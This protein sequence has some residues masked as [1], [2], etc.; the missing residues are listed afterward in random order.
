MWLGLCDTCDMTFSYT[1]SYI[2]SPK[3]KEKKYK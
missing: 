1:P 3:E 2:V